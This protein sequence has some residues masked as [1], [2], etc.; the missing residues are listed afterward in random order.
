MEN[1]KMKDLD[2]LIT[3]GKE[4]QAILREN[5]DIISF[6]RLLKELGD[7]AAIL[8]AKADRLIRAGEAAKILGVSK[9]TIYRYEREGKLQAW[10][11]ADSSQKKF[12]L[13]QVMALPERF[14]QAEF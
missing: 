7:E 9:G 1:I 14:P 3:K 10:H 8:P 6:L 11:T 12:W 5:P 4:L 13:T 2:T